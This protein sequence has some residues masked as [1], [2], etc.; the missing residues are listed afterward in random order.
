M[1]TKKILFSIIFLTTFSHFSFSQET[2][3]LLD[4]NL[5]ITG[6]GGV[7]CEFSSVKG[8]FAFFMGGR[9]AALINNKFFFG[10]YGMGMTNRIDGD[11]DNYKNVQLEFGHGGLWTGL[12]F[13]PE[14]AVHLSVSSGFGW[15][16]VSWNQKIN[17]PTLPGQFV[18]FPHDNVFV[19][20]PEV[21]AEANLLKFM[22]ASIGI[23]YRMVTGLSIEGLSS[24]SLNSPSLTISAIFGWF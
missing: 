3:Y 9:G 6:F 14:K 16:G 5:D 1:N 10:G 22:K 2:E 4:K 11:L 20:T 12:L 21:T 15:G 19:I 17:G 18:T 13:N 7:V 23:S 24:T 8:D